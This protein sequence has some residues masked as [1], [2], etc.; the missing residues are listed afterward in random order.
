MRSFASICASRKLLALGLMFSLGC[1]STRLADPA[2]SA[3]RPS[4]LYEDFRARVAAQ[5]A[6]DP[7]IGIWS[8]G[9]CGFS[10]VLA[11]V[12]NDEGTP[13]QLKA[14]ILN[15]SEVGYGFFDGHPW[16][17]ASPLAAPGTYEGR[18]T[19]RN[20]LWQR[21]FPTRIVMSGQNAFTT[22]DDVTLQTCGG[23]VHTYLRK[24]PRPDVGP[25][26]LTSGSGFLLWGSALVLTTN[27]VVEKAPRIRIRFPT[28]EEYE[29]RV[30][31]RDLGNDLALLEARGFHATIARGFK[32]D[33]RAV[34]AVGEPVHAL[35][36]PLAP[37]LSRQPSIV[38]GQVSSG[39]GLEDSP[40]QF[41]MTAP[42]NP[43]S[44]GGPILNQEGVVV[45]IAVSALR[46]RLVEGISFG[47]KIGT[48]LPLLQQ[49]GARLGAGDGG[50]FTPDQIF[51]RYA[52]DVVSIEAY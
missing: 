38:S 32:V 41:R 2:T 42:I 51:T 30:L 6:D 9:Q 12:R 17:Y 23:T 25:V 16:F 10:V 24:D 43:G 34:I 21:W 40:T 20:V 47:I 44:S 1:T 50:R 52:Q 48:A 8:G 19:Y 39:V 3:G 28:G 13:H 29:A 31:A 22:Y 7:L 27:H 4:Q 18:I 5:V 11:V 36:Y 14:V 37:A 35:G 45:G 15:G 46:H 26:R 33:P 49:T